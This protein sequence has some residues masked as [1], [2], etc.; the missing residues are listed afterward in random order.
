M[1]KWDGKTFW[2]EQDLYLKYDLYTQ[3]EIDQF[4]DMLPTFDVYG[5]PLEV[6]IDMWQNV[7][8]KVIKG[9]EKAKEIFNE[10]NEWM[11]DTLNKYG[12]VTLIGL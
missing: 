3:N 12:I 8:S 1:G 6:N 4:L 11:I 9:S 10:L 7:E 5:D 2:S